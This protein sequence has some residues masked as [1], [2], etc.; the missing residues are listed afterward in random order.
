MGV[1]EERLR[2]KKICPLCKEGITEV[3]YKDV[4]FLKN[5]LTPKA[6]IMPRKKTGVCAKH[7]RKLANAIKNARELALIPYTA[8][9]A[10][11]WRRRK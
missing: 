6:A 1:A 9:H 7:Q 11:T 5:Y 4:N 3:D 8:D 10:L 2:K